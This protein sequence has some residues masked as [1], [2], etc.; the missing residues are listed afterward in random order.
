M[1]LTS[2]PDG[3]LSSRAKLL[4]HI[5][6]DPGDVIPP[7][8]Q[9]LINQ[10]SGDVLTESHPNMLWILSPEFFKSPSVQ[11]KNLRLLRLR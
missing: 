1:S 6:D 5:N 11:T 8:S 3:R 10:I 7:S 2:I 9:R 4:P